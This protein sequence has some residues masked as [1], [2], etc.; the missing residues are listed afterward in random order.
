VDRGAIARRV[1]ED[2]GAVRAGEL[3]VVSG[4]PAEEATR[5][6]AVSLGAW[7][8]APELLDGVA[9]HLG[10][11]LA[12]YHAEH[13][14]RQGPDVGEVRTI[15]AEHQRVLSDPT[16][17][18]ALLD[19]LA[20]EGTIVREG[21]VVRLPTHRASTAGWEEADRLVAAVAEGEPAPPTVR[22]LV[23]AGFGQELIRAA[24]ADG[25]LVRISAELVVS[26]G[27]LARAEEIVRTRGGPPGLTVSA[28]RE[29]VGTSRKYALP[30]L[31]Y[32]DARGLTR[33][34]GDVRILRPG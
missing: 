25:R 32:F 15:L 13:P 33:R 11:A 16:L 23:A 28:F 20:G 8:V 34:Q 17:A 29:A 31:E 9:D 30:L 18:E 10:R 21:A 2:R 6:G 7:V 22:E 3:L 27:F 26:P 24:C 19:R 12:R 1:V 4:A 14:L 5:R